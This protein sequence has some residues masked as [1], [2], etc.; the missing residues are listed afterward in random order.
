M[1]IM[2]K[3]YL[4]LLKKTIEAIF[5]PKDICDNTSKINDFFSYEKV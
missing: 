2:L 4:V 5:I 1:M 3:R